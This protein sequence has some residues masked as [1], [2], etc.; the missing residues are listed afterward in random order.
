MT[1]FYATLIFAAS[2][3]AGFALGA[4]YASISEVDE[5]ERFVN[6]SEK[7]LDGRL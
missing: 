6:I 7:L 3:I 2:L 4:W 5:D 1:A